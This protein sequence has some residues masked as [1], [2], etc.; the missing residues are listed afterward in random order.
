MAGM[1]TLGLSSERQP[2]DNMF[3]RLFW[4]TIRE[5][6]DVDLIGYQGF[7][8][9]FALAVFSALGVFSGG[10]D[11]L[12]ALL[13]AFLFLGGA[14]GVRQ[15][16]V[17]AACLMFLFYL[18][19]TLEVLILAPGLGVFMFVRCVLLALLAANIRATVI[20]AEWSRRRPSDPDISESR[21]VTTVGDRIA[22][23]MPPIVWP[24]A[25]WCFI[26]LAII[27]VIG[28]LILNFAL[29]LGHRPP[30]SAA[31]TP[32]SPTYTVQPSN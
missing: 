24:Y 2:S 31:P 16:S 1:E 28:M 12:S 3:Q 23:Q 25:R 4:P 30:N 5:Q 10:I 14:C 6:E 21:T 27:A 13:G 11:S 9:C 19:N 32:P 29:A 8:M 26:P 18:L 22:N 20:A 15:R 7:W 17:I